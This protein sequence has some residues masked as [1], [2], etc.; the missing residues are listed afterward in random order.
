M[1]LVRTEESRQ[2]LV[3]KVG[4]RGLVL[5]VH[6]CKGLEFQVLTVL[7]QYSTIQGLVLCVHKCTNE[8]KGLDF[9]VHAVDGTGEE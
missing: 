6:E 8:L 5:C 4:S 9:Q 1:I 7:M 3:E 2:R